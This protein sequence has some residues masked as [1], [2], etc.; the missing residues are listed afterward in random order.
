MKESLT[1]HNPEKELNMQSFHYL[2]DFAAN[3]PKSIHL[4]ILSR[5]KNQVSN[6]FSKV[7]VRS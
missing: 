6:L 3:L 2:N 1:N 5:D 7:I 4:S